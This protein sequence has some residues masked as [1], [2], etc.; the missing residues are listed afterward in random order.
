LISGFPKL[1]TLDAID[2]AISKIKLQAPELRSLRVSN[3]FNLIKIEG[4]EGCP[5]LDSRFFS[6]S[7]V[8]KAKIYQNAEAVNGL[9]NQVQ[10]K[11]SQ[12]A[13][14]QSQI[15]IKEQQ[16]QGLNSQINNLNQQIN[17][18]Q[19]QINGL[20][21][22]LQ[23][24]TVSEQ[25]K[26]TQ[27]NSLNG[28]INGLNQEKVQQQTNLAQLTEQKDTFQRSAEYLREELKKAERWLEETKKELEPEKEKVR[29]LE[30][31]KAALQEN[32]QSEL[33]KRSEAYLVVQERNRELE[34]KLSGAESENGK[35]S[36]WVSKL[37]SLSGEGSA[38]EGLRKELEEANSRVLALTEELSVK[39][40][41]SY[42]WVYALLV[43]VAL[44]LV[45]G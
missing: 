26:Q 37:E 32:H 38:L 36:E 16:I 19:Q 10:S 12:I 11:E 8:T 2:L 22:Q 23:N 4:M 6:Y 24:K 14:L 28:Q 27:I 18:K 45:M 15:Q 34:K 29:G 21:T 1:N 25:Q 31:E 30:Q 33:K 20:Q 9:Q 7:D 3:C 44:Y 17:A 42:W 5:N 41:R 39:K 13:Q 43:L 35:L 40:P